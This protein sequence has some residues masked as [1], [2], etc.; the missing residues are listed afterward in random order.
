MSNLSFA[1]PAVLNTLSRLHRD[2]SETQKCFFSCLPFTCSSASSEPSSY[3]CSSPFSLGTI[4]ALIFHFRLNK[5]SIRKS[6]VFLGLR[7]RKADSR[8][9]I[10]R[11]EA[12]VRESVNL[13]SEGRS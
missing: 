9:N 7:E 10:K 1:V 13:R 11:E 8:F 6:G 3:N 4:G 2:R 12:S 5:N